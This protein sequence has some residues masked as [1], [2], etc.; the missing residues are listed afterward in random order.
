[1]LKPR[2]IVK[3]T[4]EPILPAPMIPIV[5]P[6][7]SLPMNKSGSQMSYLSARI[8]LSASTTRRAVDRISDTA[9]SAVASVKTPGVLPTA[10]PWSVA[11]ST[12]TL[13]KPTATF[14]YTFPPARFKAENNFS[15]QFS[16]SCP[17]TPSQRDPMALI[18][19]SSV[20][21][22]RYKIWSTLQSAAIRISNHL[23]PTS[24][25]VTNTLRRPC[26]LYVF[27]SSNEAIFR[28]EIGQPHNYTSN[29]SHFVNS[30][31]SSDSL[32]LKPVLTCLFRQ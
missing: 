24:G 25:L 30:M 13:S 11:A 4:D 21:I 15:S 6:C 12:L 26:G 17:T 2:T 1:M 20:N 32:N 23:R 3:A 5:F 28:R 9:I 7:N 14:V 22:P 8:N 16:V 29:A 31:H 19:W 18:I 10:I 27:I